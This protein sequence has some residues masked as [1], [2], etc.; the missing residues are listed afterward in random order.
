M[1]L[2]QKSLAEARG[3]LTKNV[4]AKRLRLES[5]PLLNNW[6]DTYI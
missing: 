5:A 1:S 3:Q 2:L 4:A 6:P